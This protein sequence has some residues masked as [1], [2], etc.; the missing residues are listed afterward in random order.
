MRKIDFISKSPQLFIFQNG[1]NQNNLGGILFLIYLVILLLLTIVYLYDYLN[2]DKYQFNYN[3]ITETYDNDSFK[4]IISKKNDKLSVNLEVKFSLSKDRQYKNF[5]SENFFMWDENN[6]RTLNPNETYIINTSNFSL[7]VL[8]I[9]NGTNC[10]I[11]EE[12]KIKERCYYLNMYYKGFTLNHQDPKEPI[13]RNNKYTPMYVE[14]L[15]KTYIYYLNWELIEY[16][17]EKGVFSKNF[18]SITGKD[19]TF[20]GGQFKSKQ[21]FLDDGHVGQ[22]YA[23]Y[24]N[25]S[26]LALLYLEIQPNYLQYDK[27]TRKGRSF[28]N[29]L[30][31]IAALSSTI[32]NLMGLSYGFFYSKNYDNYKIVENILSKKLRININ[33]TLEDKE[34]SKIELK[35]D[36]NDNNDQDEEKEKEAIDDI[37][38]TDEVHSD[39]NIKAIKLPLMRFYDFLVHKLY[40]KCFGHSNKHALIESCNDV[41]KRYISIE[42]L[43]YNQIR[44]E[45]LFK[46]YKWNNPLYDLHEKNDF[47]IQLQGKL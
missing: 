34:E 44:L 33:Q 18:D 3:L 10:T 25:N 14:F 9:C 39:K 17:E 42:N 37:N 1:A 20:Y 12:D 22:M 38:N 46:D 36:L 43:I 13:K 45:S 31:E 2:N 32:I 11:R 21:V 26:V 47:L 24:E 35:T 30:A 5:N 23:N 28:L 40:F 4:N 29:V 7:V 8:Y 19:N 27:Y 16:E 41:L 6:R 15:E